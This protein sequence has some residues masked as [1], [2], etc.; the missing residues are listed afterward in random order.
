MNKVLYVGKAINLKER[1]ASYARS[2]DPK[3]KILTSKI[4][5]IDHTIVTSE[6]EALL[7][8]AHLIKT[9]Q[10]FFNTRVKDDKRPLYIKIT[11]RDEFPR[12]FMVR[13]EDEK[14]SLYF[15]PFPSSGNLR[16]VLK[17]LR[18][19]FSYDTQKT[20]GKR[21]C[22]WSHIGLCSPCPSAIKTK[23][24][25][26]KYKK[27][28]RHLVGVL[29]RKTSAVRRSLVNQ[30]QK[31][32]EKNLFE[33]AAE[34]RDQIT[35]LDYITRAYHPISSFL[36]NPNLV[37]D[38]RRQEL[39]SLKQILTS[40]PRRQAGHFPFLP[41]VSHIEC[42]DA[43]HTGMINPT[44]GMVT[45]ING[46]PDKNFYRKFRIKDKNSSDD[47]SFL[48]EALR[49]RFKHVDWGMP[50]LVVID[51]GKTQV[52]R[53]R[54]VLESLNMKIPVVG[55]VKPFDDLVIP[56]HEGFLIKR[57]R[58]PAQRL[59]QRLRDEAHRFALSYHRKLRKRNFLNLT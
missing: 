22:F 57:V 21:A 39:I 19:I 27:N 32:A 26:A 43:S 33:E 13:Q 1:V 51:G 18:R 10:P 29:S 15:G 12:V 40:L 25:K 34:I 9:Y 23:E 35:K 5:K 6:L 4:K 59:L 7:L 16:Q 20:L 38:I 49:R 17:F 52:G 46:E 3:T 41:S 44:V 24:E 37:S 53:A 2:S 45:F 11:I 50:D 55:V 54:E 36:E 30:M 48:E 31:L 8:E 56:H 42:F 28:I 58:G 47:L 14:K